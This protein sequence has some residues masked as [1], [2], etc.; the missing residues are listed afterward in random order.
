M[1]GTCA[2][3]RVTLFPY[4]GMRHACVGAGNGMAVWGYVCIT[5][6]ASTCYGCNVHF[7]VHY[8]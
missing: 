7:S 8:T 6:D 1:V 2:H 5:L 3:V 4:I